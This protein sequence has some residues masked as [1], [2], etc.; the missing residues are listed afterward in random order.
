MGPFFH[1]LAII[2]IIVHILPTSSFFLPCNIHTSKSYTSTN[3]VNLNAKAEKDLACATLQVAG[4]DTYF[5]ARCRTEAKTFRGLNGNLLQ[6]EEGRTGEKTN[7]KEK[8]I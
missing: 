8:E 2:I 3:H 1:L 5:R 6:D 4:V 7:E